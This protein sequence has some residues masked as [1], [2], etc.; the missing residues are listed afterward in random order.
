MSKTEAAQLAHVAE[1]KCKTG[2]GTVIAETYGGLEV[3]VQ[4]GAPGI[5][6][7]K[8][9]PVPEDIVVACASFAPLSTRKFLYEEETRERVN[10]VGGKLVDKLIEEPDYLNFMRLSRQFAEHVGLITVRMRKVLKETDG[11]NFVCSMSMFGETLFT[12]AE[13]KSLERLLKIFDKYFPKE[14]IVVS[15]INIGGA[16]LLP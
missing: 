6:E 10:D 13:R 16:R 8:N 12:L 7:I 2:L 1:I 14:K 4:P 9:I 11:A 15:E 3:R 5:G